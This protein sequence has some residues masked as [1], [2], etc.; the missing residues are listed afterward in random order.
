[1][2]IGGC[3][4]AITSAKEDHGCGYYTNKIGG[5]PVTVEVGCMCSN[6]YRQN[7]PDTAPTIPLTCKL[8]QSPMALVIQVI[9]PYCSERS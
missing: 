9:W 1:M 4:S 7:W 8:C 3:D 6:N 2:T 5:Q